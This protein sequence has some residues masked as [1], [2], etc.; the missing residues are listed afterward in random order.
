MEHVKKRML[1]D[2]NAIGARVQELG[3]QIS[4]DCPEGNLLLIGILKGSFVFLADLAR[5]LSLPC[6]ID[7][8]RISSYGTATVSSGELKVIMDVGIPVK[9]RHVILVDDIVDS[10][11]T[12]SEYRR[13]IELSNPKSLKIAAMIDKTARREKHVHLDY[14]GFRIDDGFLVGYGLDWDEKFRNLGGIYVIEP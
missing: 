7:F 8:A 1:Y 12:L 5:S 6:Q 11:L 10:G 13:R 4:E 3:K 2:A 9:D 14:Y